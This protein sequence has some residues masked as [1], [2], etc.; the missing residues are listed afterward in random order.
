MAG[1]M[2]GGGAGGGGDFNAMLERVPAIPITD[3]KIGDQIIVSSTKSA[4]ADHVTAITI[5]A[6]VEPLLAARQAAATP[7]G[8]RQGSIG[9]GW[10]MDIPVL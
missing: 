3:M 9:S 10:S 7:A 6:G 8:G 5:L 1:G 4:T 2:R